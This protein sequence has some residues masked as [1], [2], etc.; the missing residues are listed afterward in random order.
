MEQQRCVT[1]LSPRLRTVAALQACKLIF[2]FPSIVR[3]APSW[4]P[5]RLKIERPTSSQLTMNRMFRESD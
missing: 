5:V 2:C 1:R 4:S 3:N